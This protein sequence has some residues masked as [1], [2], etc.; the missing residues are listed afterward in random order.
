MSNILIIDGLNLF[1]RNYINSPSLGNNGQPTGGLIGTIKSL[2]K[3]IRENSPDE[4]YF[5]WDGPKSAIRRRSVNSEYKEGR[6]PIRLNRNFG[7]LNEQE[8]K[9]NRYWQYSRVVE[10]L[11]QMPIAQIYL[12]YVEADDVISVLCKELPDD[13]KVIVSN[14]KD[15]FQLL[16]ENTFLYRPCIE[17]TYDIKK[18][19][20]EFDI[21]PTNF[22]LARSIV[23]D[24][25][26]NLPGAKGVGLKTMAKRFPSIKE[27]RPIM[28]T[29]IFD[30]CKN[31]PTPLKIHNSILESE[32][33][34]KDN[35]EI[36]QLYS[37][38]I[39]L[40]SRQKI[41]GIIENYPWPFNKTQL[42]LMMTQDG[43]NNIQLV[44]LF[45]SL[46][47]IS[48]NSKGKK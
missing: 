28:L 19:I 34:I 26:D 15:F 46:N 41:R 13:K 27:E 25:S 1:I 20:N 16:D 29:E 23:G 10:Y 8:E 14:D 11:N 24:A 9:E 32:K 45:A 48:L 42:R 31:E 5:C 12:D 40:E 36:M 37:P 43:A 2:Q 39:S 22:A 7:D 3:L 30:L 33:V 44:D 35:Y 18:L 47:K 4:I 38:S 17:Q 6:K 21:H